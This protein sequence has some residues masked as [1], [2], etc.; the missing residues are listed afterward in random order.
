MLL[1]NRRRRR[2][3][4]TLASTVLLF[5]CSEDPAPGGVRVPGKDESAR[6]QILETGAHMLQDK[7]PLRAFDSY[8][9]GFHFASGDMHM[10]MEAHH[11]CG[12]LNQDV[13]Q[14]VLFDGKGSEARLA[15][16]EY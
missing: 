2:A 8:L 7:A 10:Q 14:C 1:L 3:L 13:I 9:D 11:Y 16:V 6:T 4:W 5:S 12:H 15:G